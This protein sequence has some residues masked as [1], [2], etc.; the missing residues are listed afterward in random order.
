MALFGSGERTIRS[1]A[2]PH[3]AWTI[4][5]KELCGRHAV[6]LEVADTP[7]RLFPLVHISKLKRM[8][9]FPDR[10]QNQLQV[11]EADR[12]DFDEA[13]LPEDSWGRTLHED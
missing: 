1:K 11:G 5:G 8:K 6:R 10:P 4:P 12:L 13:M 7:Y 3:V 9:I 2:G